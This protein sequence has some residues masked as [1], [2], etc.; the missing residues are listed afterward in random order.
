MQTDFC[1]CSSEWARPS[2]V[3]HQVQDSCGNAGD[4]LILENLRVGET[5]QRSDVILLHERAQMLWTD[6]DVWHDVD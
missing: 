2:V 1:T 4:L 6:V 3:G 5:Q